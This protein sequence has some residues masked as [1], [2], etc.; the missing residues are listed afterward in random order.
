MFRRFFVA[1]NLLSEIINGLMGGVA[2][3]IMGG[4][5]SAPMSTGEQTANYG[6]NPFIDTTLY[7]NSLK[8]S[9]ILSSCSSVSS[10]SLITS[11]S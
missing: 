11:T 7:F 1:S 5:Q 8:S 9:V 4:G 6:Q 2:N 3:G 10:T